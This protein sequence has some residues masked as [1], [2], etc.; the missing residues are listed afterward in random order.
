[1]SSLRIGADLAYVL[2]TSQAAPVI[3]T[4]SPELIVLP[5]L[6]DENN[7][8]EMTSW[9]AKCHAIVIGPGLGRSLQAETNLKVNSYEQIKTKWI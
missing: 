8:L 4:Y 9:I 3:K 6:D 7:V 2:T 5:I 1:M